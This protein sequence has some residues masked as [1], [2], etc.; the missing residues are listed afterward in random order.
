LCLIHKNSRL[1]QDELLGITQRIRDSEIKADAAATQLRNDLK[2]ALTLA[3]T[4]SRAEA[5]QE[6][7]GRLRDSERR[8]LARVQVAGSLVSE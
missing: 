8:V 6:A 3:S 7:A 1:P 5:E 2:Q 4:S